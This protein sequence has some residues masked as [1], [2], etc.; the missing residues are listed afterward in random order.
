MTTFPP[1]PAF[2]LKQASNISPKRCRDEHRDAIEEEDRVA[3]AN[4][5]FGIRL[6]WILVSS[7]TWDKHSTF[8]NLSVLPGTMG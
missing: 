7:V 8:L 4:E 5:G 3:P 1:A 6:S 2:S